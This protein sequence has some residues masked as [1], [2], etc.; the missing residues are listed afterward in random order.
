MNMRNSQADI[1]A[2]PG[3]KIASLPLIIYHRGKP[4]TTEG[5]KRPWCLKR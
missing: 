3:G 4:V 1:A 2:A 5:L